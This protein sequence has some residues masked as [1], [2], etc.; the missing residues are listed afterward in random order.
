MDTLRWKKLSS[1]GCLTHILYFQLD[2]LDEDCNAIGSLWP[3]LFIGS[4]IKPKIDDIVFV[5]PIFARIWGTLGGGE[6]SSNLGSRQKILES[7]F[8]TLGL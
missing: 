3:K 5:V 8:C 7:L 2:T 6:I 1:D 4:T